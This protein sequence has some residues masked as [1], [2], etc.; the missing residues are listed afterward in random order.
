MW[1]CGVGIGAKRVKLHSR[2]HRFH[3]RSFDFWNG[4]AGCR[5]IATVAVPKVRYVRTLRSCFPFEALCFCRVIRLPASLPRSAARGSPILAVCCAHSFSRIFGGFLSHV[6]ALL[7]SRWYTSGMATMYK[8]QKFMLSCSVPTSHTQDCIGATVVMAREH[9]VC[10]DGTMRR[11]GG[12]TREL[13]ALSPHLVRCQLATRTHT[14]GGRLLPICFYPW[15]T[16]SPDCR[17]HEALMRASYSVAY[18]QTW[19]VYVTHA[20]NFTC[21]HV[22]VVMFMPT[23]N[24]IPSGY[25]STVSGNASHLVGNV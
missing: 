14:A 19:R 8:V 21:R 11:C 7:S 23:C 3:T 16:R 20:V 2:I 17:V 1:R 25:C 22:L 12:S 10:S 9:R 15:K 13:H 6:Q 4:C 5:Q 18:A 24:C